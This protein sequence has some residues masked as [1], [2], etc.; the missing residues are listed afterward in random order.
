MIVDT[1]KFNVVIKTQK[2]GKACN[3]FVCFGGLTVLFYL[4]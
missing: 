4:S 1:S 3:G 2:P